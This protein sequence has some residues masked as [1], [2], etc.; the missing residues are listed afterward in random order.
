MLIWVDNAF[1][2]QPEEEST[3][4]GEAHQGLPRDRP[5][6][7]HMWGTVIYLSVGEKK[8]PSR[9]DLSTP[10]ARSRHDELRRTMRDAIPRQAMIDIL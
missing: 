1:M 6:G 5:D 3:I 2:G 9:E 8:T 4:Y 10:E 7:E